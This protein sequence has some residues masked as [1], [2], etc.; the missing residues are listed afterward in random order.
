VLVVDG[1]IRGIWTH[2]DTAGSVAI[3]VTPFG[4]VSPA[5]KKSAAEHAQ[6]YVNLFGAPVTLRWG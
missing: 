4:R 1:V 2:E 6:R 3:K 5:T